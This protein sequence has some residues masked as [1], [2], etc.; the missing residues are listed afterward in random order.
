MNNLDNLCVIYYSGEH[1]VFE[2]DADTIDL[3]NVPLNGGVLVKTLYLSVDPYLRGRMRDPKI[4]S[5]SSPLEVGKPLSNTSA[6]HA[7]HLKSV[8]QR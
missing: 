3:E 8:A 2:P 4:P 5:Y 6:L 1:L 7:F